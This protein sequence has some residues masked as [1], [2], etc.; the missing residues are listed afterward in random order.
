MQSFYF[1][2]FYLLSKTGFE[3]ASSFKREIR[4]RFV[5]VHD[6]CFVSSVKCDASRLLLQSFCRGP[7]PLKEKKDLCVCS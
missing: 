6:L 5:H 7:V 3:R 1:D 4:R 2:L